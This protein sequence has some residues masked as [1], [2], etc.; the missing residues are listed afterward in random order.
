MTSPRRRKTGPVSNSAISVSP[1]PTLRAT[2]AN[3]P[4]NSD[5]RRNGSSSDTGLAMR[6]DGRRGSSGVEQ[7]AV[8]DGFVDERRREDL[9]VPGIGEGAA[10]LPAE[11][12]R[13]GET[14]AGRRGRHQGR[15]RGIALEPDDLLDQVGGDPQVRPP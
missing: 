10:D 13:P 4:G 7:Q 2:A 11:P 12:L 9:D 3:S 15:Q 5:V 14:T 1:R 8:G 6:T